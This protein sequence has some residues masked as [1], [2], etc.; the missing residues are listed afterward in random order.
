[1]ARDLSGILKLWTQ[2]VP[3]DTALAARAFEEHYTNPVLVNG[4]SLPCSGLVERARI[5]QRAFTDLKIH[6][7][8]QVDTV[9]HSAIAF[10]QTGKHTGPLPTALGEV[11]AT[12]EEVERNIIDILTF[13]DG[14]V[15]EV[16]VVGDELGLLVA[17]N[18]VKLS[19]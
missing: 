5:Q 6:V 14:R 4:K 1:M 15:C 13:R 17:L 16:R 9:D 12:G 8:Q 7:L 3:D 18:A 19:P 11:A 10:R 2:P